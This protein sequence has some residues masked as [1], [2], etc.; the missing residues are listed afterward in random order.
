MGSVKL[1][2]LK[3]KQKKRKTKHVYFK[4]VPIRN[5]GYGCTFF[6]REQWC[7]FYWF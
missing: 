3:K 1:L 5:Q 4:D 6:S 2:K 7:V